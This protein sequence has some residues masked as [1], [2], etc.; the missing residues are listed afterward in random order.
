MPLVLFVFPKILWHLEAGV[1]QV[2]GIAMRE[3]AAQ[4]ASDPVSFVPW[5]QS[6]ATAVEEPQREEAVVRPSASIPAM[7]QELAVLTREFHL[8][9]VL[10]RRNGLG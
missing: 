7:Q 5:L 10:K 6:S 4:D 8:M 9:L 2:P 3:R 1:R